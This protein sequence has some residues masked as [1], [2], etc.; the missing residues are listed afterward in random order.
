MTWF[1]SRDFLEKL[2]LRRYDAAAIAKRLEMDVDVVRR[3][4]DPSRRYTVQTSNYGWIAGTGNDQ[5]VLVFI[6]QPRLS[7]GDQ[8][9]LNAVLFEPDG[10]VRTRAIPCDDAIL[11]DEEALLDLLYDEIRF[12]HVGTAVVSAFK[13]PQL[14]HYALV[15]FPWSLHEIAIGEADGELSSVREWIEAGRF[16]LHCGNDYWLDAEGEV[17]S[18]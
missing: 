15:P 6:G 3:F 9:P 11:A 5:P 10:T 2:D 4:V 8:E 12:R 17:E 14:W 1:M 7:G 13:H 18:S 16:V